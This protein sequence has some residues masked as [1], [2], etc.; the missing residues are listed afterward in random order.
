MISFELATALCVGIP[1]AGFVAMVVA[2]RSVV[3]HNRFLIDRN[4]TLIENMLHIGNTEPYDVKHE[5]SGAAV[6]VYA[7]HRHLGCDLISMLK[8][9]PYD[10]ED[11]E[12]RA[13]AIREAEEMVEAIRGR[14]A[15]DSSR[16][17][18]KET[19]KEI[20]ARAS[21]RVSGHPES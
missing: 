12:D 16:E 1:V 11:A 18:L 9:I 5:D 3:R 14:N 13:F 2:Y 8:R 15:P 10:G 6:Y 21:L 17:R 7:L 19:V 4:D 20:V